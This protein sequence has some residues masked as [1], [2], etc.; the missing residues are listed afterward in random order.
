MLGVIC[1]V[2]SAILFFC[3]SMSWPLG[4]IHLVPTGLLFFVLG[5]LLRTINP[6]WTVVRKRRE[7]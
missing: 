4:P 2:V 7:P 3:A 6:T 5:H 1:L